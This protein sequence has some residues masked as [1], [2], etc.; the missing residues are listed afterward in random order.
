MPI[1]DFVCGSCAHRFEEWVRKAE[2]VP[3]CPECG[4]TEVTRELSLPQVHSSTTRDNS[5]RDAKRRE[6]AGGKER[7]HAQRQYELSHND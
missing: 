7:A 1:Y 3:P 2:T 4:A 6:L 5:L